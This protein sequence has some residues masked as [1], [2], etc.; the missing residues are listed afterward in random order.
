MRIVDR[1]AYINHDI[2]DA[3][4]YWA[5]TPG[6]PPREELD[7][8]GATG[9]QRIDTL[10]HDL[11]ETS[12]REGRIR[13]GEEVGEAMHSLRAF[14][15]EQVYPGPGTPG[16]Q[17][18]ATIDRI[19]EL[20]VAEPGRLPVGDGELAD[21]VVD[22]VSGMTDCFALERRRSCRSDGEDQ[23]HV[24]A[25]GNRGRRHGRG[26]LSAHVAVDRPGRG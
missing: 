3:L 5:P 17:A 15:F 8:L 14:M 18:A 6:R 4:R 2:D 10:V 12:E 23:G 20:L 11:V 24:R 13:Q 25:R 21:R 26:R 9:T 7:V 1:V 16:A 19:V 22:Y